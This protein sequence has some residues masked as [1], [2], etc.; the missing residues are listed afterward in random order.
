MK[1]PHYGSTGV[2]EVYAGPY[3]APFRTTF[4]PTGNTSDLEEYLFRSFTGELRSEGYSRENEAFVE[5]LIVDDEL[6]HMM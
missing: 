6:D 3:Q 5:R 4:V 2:F 1:H